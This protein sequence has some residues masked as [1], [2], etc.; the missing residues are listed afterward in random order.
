MCVC[1]AVSS[2]TITIHWKMSVMRIDEYVFVYG[3]A[4][5]EFSMSLSEVSRIPRLVITKSDDSLH[6]GQI[7]EIF[8]LNGIQDLATRTYSCI[9]II[10]I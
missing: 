8:S 9:H 10:K 3:Y 5:L 1:A 6:A 4:L 2:I 7:A